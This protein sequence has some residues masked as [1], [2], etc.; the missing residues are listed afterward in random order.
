[1]PFIIVG[2]G[3]DDTFIIHGAFI[4]TDRKKSPAQRI[5]DTFEEVGTSVFMTSATTALA[6]GLGCMSTIPAITYLCYYAFP[7]IL[8]DFIYQITFF[9]ALI[10][11]DERRIEAK[12]MDCC[13]CTVPGHQRGMEAVHSESMDDEESE[14][15]TVSRLGPRIMGWYAD[16]LKR[17][18]VKGMVFLAFAAFLAACIQ[19]SLLLKQ[20]FSFFDLLPDYSASKTYYGAQQIHGGIIKEMYVFFRDLNQSDSVIQDQMLNYMDEI[21]ALDNIEEMPFCWFRDIRDLREDPE[22]FYESRMADP[23]TA[24]LLEAHPEVLDYLKH[25]DIVKGMSVNQV[26]NIALEQ[27]LINALYSQHIVRNE[28]GD[29]INSRCR[30]LVKN[31]NGRDVND[32]IRLF[33]AQEAITISHPLNQDGPYYHCFLYNEIFHLWEFFRVAIEEL[34]YTAFTGIIVVSIFAVVFVPHWTAALYI[35]PLMCI[36]YV[37]LLGKFHLFRCFFLVRLPSNA[38]LYAPL[39]HQ[40]YSIW[41]GCPS[42]C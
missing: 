39:L 10:V 41:P 29:V 3:L 18:C 4:H 32:Q 1:L 27:P 5:H 35:F 16:Q 20:E 13:L 12:R 2:V 17:P 11:L 34:K 42:T 14:E 7:T 8:I 21:E 22:A 15:S 38:K 26:L 6:F 23:A 9:V 24:R 37:D 25:S 40:A 30:V 36:L 31:L 33:E 19:N 28:H